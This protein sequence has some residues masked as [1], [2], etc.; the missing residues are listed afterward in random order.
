MIKRIDEDCLYMNVYSPYVGS[1]IPDPYP[2]MV[3][4]HGG[5][6]DHGSGNVFPGHMLAASQKVVVV[7]FNYRLGLLGEF[8][9][10][11]SFLLSF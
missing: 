4:I 8:T 5:N 1:M 9:L 11:M 6:F 7:T 3:Y 2:V 10:F